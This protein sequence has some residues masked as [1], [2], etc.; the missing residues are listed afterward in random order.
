M[1]SVSCGCIQ[2]H[3]DMQL[4]CSEPTRSKSTAAVWEK[5]RHAARHMVYKIYW[6][7]IAT[8]D[9]LLPGISSSQLPSVPL[10]SDEM[11]FTLQPQDHIRPGRFRRTR[12]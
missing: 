12:A 11:P 9:V 5:L 4:S 1:P 10:A 3:L 7:R 8:R 2:R 6:G